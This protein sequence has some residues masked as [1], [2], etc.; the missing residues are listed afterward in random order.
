MFAGPLLAKATGKAFESQRSPRPRPENGG[1]EGRTREASSA[2]SEEE[3]EEGKRKRRTPLSR[4]RRLSSRRRRKAAEEE[5]EGEGEEGS[6][7]ETSGSDDADGDGGENL[8]DFDGDHTQAVTSLPSAT[9]VGAP[10]FPLVS[11][12]AS[13]RWA[14]FQGSA[15][16]FGID[17]SSFVAGLGRSAQ[18]QGQTFGR[19]VV[20]PLSSALMEAAVCLL[21]LFV[22]GASGVKLGQRLKRIFAPAPT[23][24]A[25]EQQIVQPGQ[26]IDESFFSQG[27]NTEELHS[28]ANR[29]LENY[30]KSLKSEDF[31]AAYDLLSPEWREELSY[32]TFEGG[33]R[34]TRV[35][36]YS[37]GKAET[38]DQRHVRIK[39]EIEV[40]ENGRRKVL[41][42]LYLAVLSSQ[43]W[44]LDGGTFR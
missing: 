14:S 9:G 6:S 5:S 41:E 19:E 4:S 16:R 30:L 36:A 29:V 28:R 10:D 21:L 43:G 33:Y 39:A 3:E 34:S 13:E 8:G 18:E 37:I 15:R 38:V 20:K 17:F 1:R 32:S 26:K 31:R 12:P 27:F 44:R 24:L 40:E 25:M 11:V 2:M 35:T 7:G 22:M 23:A 42:A